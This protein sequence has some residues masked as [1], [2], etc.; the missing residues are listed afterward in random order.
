M[1]SYARNMAKH[2]Y[3][4]YI[5]RVKWIIIPFLLSIIVVLSGLASYLIIYSG[6]VY[7]NINVAEVSLS[8]YKLND[9][10]SVLSVKTEVPTSLTLTYQDQTF[11]IAESDINLSYNFTSSAIAAYS[12]TRTGNLFTDLVRRLNLLFHPKNFNLVINFDNSELTKIVS[13][14]SGQISID[15]IEPTVTV[16]NGQIVINKGSAG[17]EVDQDKLV[18][19]IENSF[20]TNDS[21]NIEISVSIV[22]DSLNQT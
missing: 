15:P 5:K 22:D 9:S 13:I 6:R 4:K 11:E 14:I 18:A 20:V 19:L 17:K 7:P 2:R 8:G 21:S 12:Y 3:I 10:I 1:V 16:V